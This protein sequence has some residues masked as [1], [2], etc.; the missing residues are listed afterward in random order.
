MMNSNS[1]NHEVKILKELDEAAT[2]LRSKGSYV[3]ALSCMERGLIMRQ[4]LYGLD[5]DELLKSCEAV[6]EVCNELAISYLQQGNMTQVLQLLKKAKILTR[7]YPRGR[8]VTL[9]NLAC[10]YRKLGNLHTALVHLEKALKIEECLG[11]G[12]GNGNIAD[13]HLNLCAVLS[14]L[15]RHEVALAHAKSGVNLIKNELFGA[16]NDT[17]EVA[18]EGNNVKESLINGPRGDRMAVLV[19][20]YHN[21]GAEQEFLSQKEASLHSFCKGVEVAIRYLDADHEIVGIIQNSAAAARKA[22]RTR[23]KSS[24]QQ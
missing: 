2:H 6:A 5:S 19:I 9:N 23:V 4:R 17:E 20:A 7:K 12:K 14:Q 18:N 15:G 3:E 8:A 22:L 13:T 24:Q 10:Y 21:L 11:G 1:N 16:L